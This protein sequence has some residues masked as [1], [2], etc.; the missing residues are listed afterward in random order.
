MSWLAKNVRLNSGV[1]FGVKS[2]TYTNRSIPKVVSLG[3]VTPFNSL[4]FVVYSR[5]MHFLLCKSVRLNFS[6]FFRVTV[7]FFN[8]TFQT[9]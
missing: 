4:L 7:Q 6:W 5:K 8:T 3:T 1:F 9:V 2:E